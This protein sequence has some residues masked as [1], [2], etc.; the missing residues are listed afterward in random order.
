MVLASPLTILLSSSVVYYAVY[1]AFAHFDSNVLSKEA[2]KKI[3]EWITRREGS[4]EETQ[5]P[6]QFLGL[7]DRL[8]GK[9]HLSVKCF[10][11]SCLV[12]LAVLTLA[13]VLWAIARP[14]SAVLYA[15]R[16]NED[17]AEN[18]TFFL[19]FNILWNIC[20]DYLP[21]LACRHILGIMG[22]RSV[23]FTGSLGYALLG[24]LASVATYI[25][26][27]V[28]LGLFVFTILWDRIFPVAMDEVNVVF[29]WY[30]QD[31]WEN[32]LFFAARP[33]SG[34]IGVP[35]YSALFTSVWAWVYVASTGIIRTLGSFDP[36]LF[37]L[38][39]EVRR[40][41]KPLAVIGSVAGILVAF[42]WCLLYLASG[43]TP[44][45]PPTLLPGLSRWLAVG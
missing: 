28:Y 4:I 38:R 41:D 14:D 24:T 13:F 15:Q 25:F 8:F 20:L 45:V 42:M 35:F 3:A 33:G 43:S 44:T 19:I 9:R 34:S 18:L 1:R 21:L 40:S 39:K 29:T 16:M 7:F 22:S 12:S 6:R 23:S 10:L 2:K 37:Y 5:W 26:L 32:G 30:M 31:L 36:V 27:T 11:R 17:L